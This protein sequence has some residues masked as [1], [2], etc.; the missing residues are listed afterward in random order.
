MFGY[1]FWKASFTTLGKSLLSLDCAQ[2]IA[3]IA[4]AANKITCFMIAVFKLLGKYP[5]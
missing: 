2:P 5:S 4:I 1:S 3:L